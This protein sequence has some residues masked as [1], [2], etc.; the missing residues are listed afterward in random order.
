MLDNRREV[1]GDEKEAH[2]SA[3]WRQFL[4][5][6][7]KTHKESCMRMMKS[8]ENITANSLFTCHIGVHSLLLI[9]VGIHRDLH[10]D[11]EVVRQTNQSRIGHRYFDSRCLKGLKMHVISCE[12]DENCEFFNQNMLG[13]GKI[14]CVC[15]K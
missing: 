15:E 14:A 3:E 11:G 10:G 6:A 1:V 5:S 8:F 7:I 9:R 2:L 13:L 4:E 12:L